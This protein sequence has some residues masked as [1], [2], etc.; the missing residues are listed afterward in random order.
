MKNSEITKRFKELKAEIDHLIEWPMS[1]PY[2]DTLQDYIDNQAVDRNLCFVPNLT[3]ILEKLQ[4]VVSNTQSEMDRIA[5][6][7]SLV[8]EQDELKT[9]K[10]KKESNK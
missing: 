8:R 3:Y 9:A 4:L 5:L 6:L 10:A 2:K 7:R 1:R